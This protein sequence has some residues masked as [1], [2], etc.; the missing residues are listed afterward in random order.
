[1]K[2]L[3]VVL[4]IF[5]SCTSIAQNTIGLTQ[6][7]LPNTEGYVLFS[8]TPNT[9]TYLIDKCG[10]QVKTWNSTFRPG[11]SVYLLED[12]SLLRTGNANNNHFTS[13]GRGGVIEKYDWNGGLIWEYF[14]SDS[15]QCQHHDVCPLPNGNI[16]AIVWDRHSI[17]EAIQHGKNPSTAATEWWSEKIMELQPIGNDSAA[18]VWEWKLWDHMVQQFDSTKPGYGVVADHPE[19]VDINSDSGPTIN[20]DWI[21]L[22]SIAFNA[23]LNQIMVSAHNPNEIWIIDHSTTSQHAAMHTGGNAGKGGDLL[24]RWGNPQMYNRGTANDQLLYGQHHATWIPA[25]YPNEG[26]IIVFNNGLDRPTGAYSSIEIIDPPLDSSNLYF[27]SNGN[28]YLPIS[29]Y[30]TY[31]APTPTNFYGS[32]ISGVYPQMNGSFLITVG[33]TGT[34]FEI[35]SGKNKAWEYINP[36]EMGGPVQ[37][38]NSAANNAVFRAALYEPDFAGFT[39]KTLIPGNEIELNP[40]SPALCETVSVLSATE[41]SKVSAYPNPAAD[42]LFVEN[43]DN[44][45]TLIVELWSVSGQKI[46]SAQLEGENKKVSINNMPNGMYLLHVYNAKGWLKSIKVIIAK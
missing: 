19:L 21:H 23:S 25:G 29:S 13:G 9:T 27:I 34:M 28:A 5:T 17:A 44:H 36:V 40:T 39:G 38:G 18:V 12:G 31:T 2:K 32:N 22:N 41:V 14:I 26:K 4:L 46:L 35:D 42:Y 15:F 3:S 30:W 45:E 6:Y 8:P 24:Y 37:Q 1:M 11:Q 16:L 10:R 20:K 43:D 33:P 7:S